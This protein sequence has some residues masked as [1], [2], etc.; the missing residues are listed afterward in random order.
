MKR[1]V[2]AGGFGFFGGAIVEAL[3]AEGLSPLVGSRRAGADVMI[4]VE[5]NTSISRALRHGDVVVDAVGPF[6]N[7]S[8][9]LLEAAIEVG[10]D[11]IDLADSLSF[12]ASVYRLRERID[13]A[14]IRVL[15]ACSGISSV[16][17]CAVRL[18]GLSQ[19]VRVTGFLVPATRHT[20][21]AGTAASLFASV[22][23]PIEVFA[24]GALRPQ[25]GWGSRRSFPMPEPVGTRTGY[26]FESADAITLPAVWPSLKSVEFY[27]DTNVRGLNA[28]FCLAARV[29]LMRK[30]LDRL[31][32]PGLR[33][34]RWLGRSSG[35]LG[36]EVESADARIVRLT[37]TAATRGYMTAIAPAVIAAKLLAEDRGQEH[38]LI[39]PDR[40]VAPEQFLAYVQRHGICYS[41]RT[42]TRRTNDIESDLKRKRADHSAS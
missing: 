19:P 4:D 20:A 10:F 3:R 38:G 37:F 23:R 7:R 27:V 22:G 14:R 1:I 18:S 15:T 39:P 31:Q 21:V 40:H 16:S 17:A 36:Y 41:M 28:L 25:Q 8:T 5:D 6:Q 35:G 34:S 29:P 11:V 33:M 9:R 26:M 32:R 24:D 30:V 13:G 42:E 2:V 12:V